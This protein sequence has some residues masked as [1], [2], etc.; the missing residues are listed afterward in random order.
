[1][2]PKTFGANDKCNFTK[3]VDLVK[4]GVKLKTRL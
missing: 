3:G 2:I 1:M 4:S